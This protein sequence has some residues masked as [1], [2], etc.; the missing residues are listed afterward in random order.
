MRAIG[1]AILLDDNTSLRISFKE[2]HNERWVFPYDA[3][4][5]LFQ[6]G[7]SVY[8]IVRVYDGCIILYGDSK[9]PSV[10]VSGQQ[11]SSKEAVDLVNICKFVAGQENAV[12]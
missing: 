6:N 12:N 2:G 3:G 1:T 5:L 7:V 4:L 8:G 11:I 10:L 9:D